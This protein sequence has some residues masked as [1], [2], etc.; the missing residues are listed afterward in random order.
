MSYGPKSGMDWQKECGSWVSATFGLQSLEDLP[1][2]AARVAEEGVE[3]AQSEKVPKEQ[4][5]AI[6]ERAYSRPAGEPKQ[7]AAGVIFTIFAYAHAKGFSLLSA[8]SRE[9]KRVRSKDPEIFRAKQR[10]KYVAGTDRI[11]PI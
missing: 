10:E 4:V 2:R 8:L 3:L 6:V 5:L 9:L 1:N 11:A 7:E